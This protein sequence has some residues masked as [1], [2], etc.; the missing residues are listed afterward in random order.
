MHRL[1]K[2]ELD[3]E[4]VD[5]DMIPADGPAPYAALF[6]SGDSR[7]T[8]FEPPLAGDGF[9]K[10]RRRE[11][12]LSHLVG[13]GGD[14][15]LQVCV[16]PGLT[17]LLEPNTRVLALYPDL[18]RNATVSRTVTDLR[19]KRLDDIK[20]IKGVDLLKV[21]MRGGELAVLQGGRQTL[22]STVAIHTDVAFVQIYK[23]QPTQGDIDVEMRS[24]GFVFHH[25]VGAKCFIMAAGAGTYENQAPSSQLITAEAIYLRDLSQH[26]RLNDEQLKQMAVI[27][28][29]YGLF[30]E[31][32]F[33]IG[34]LEQ[35]RAIPNGTVLRYMGV[36]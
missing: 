12:Y 29:H 18:R 14:H 7:L 11:R 36:N 33:C 19:T 2:P 4:I 15:S 16:H 1:L 5:V 8:R 17:S 34:H 31:A 23:D 26:E 24:Q 9:P 13:D 27:C 30:D 25:F 21:S 35:R 6:E 32:R 10:A 3:T 28:H 20:A 22:K